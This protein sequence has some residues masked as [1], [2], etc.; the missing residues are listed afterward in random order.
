ME[1]FLY[2]QVSMKLDTMVTKK[3]IFTNNTL[4]YCAYS[5]IAKAQNLP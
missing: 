5:H 1:T 3:S 4:K 2:G